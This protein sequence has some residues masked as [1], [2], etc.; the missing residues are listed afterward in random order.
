M[1]RHPNRRAF[2]C[3]S[4][5]FAFLMASGGMLSACSE[6]TGPADIRFDRDTCEH[7]RM[8]ISDRHFPASIRG[9]PRHAAHK[10]DDIGCA[11]QWLGRQ[12]WASEAKT[13]IWVG[14]YENP[15]TWLKAKE[16][17]YISGL[18][19]PMDYGFGAVA[20]PHE[21]A[22]DFAAMKKAVLERDTA[23]ICSPS[24]LARRLGEAEKLASAAPQSLAAGSPAK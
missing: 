24:R 16:A 3:Q 2:L 6:E 5:S 17:V 23:Q 13:E 14:D 7:C 18:V 21:G 9:G 1:S 22:V 15:G 12:E 19:T 20:A 8:M 11:M 10:F 4:A